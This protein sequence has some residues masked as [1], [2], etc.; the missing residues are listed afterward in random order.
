MLRFEQEDEAKGADPRFG[1]LRVRGGCTVIASADGQIRYVIGKPLPRKAGDAAE[2][3]A[4][5][6]EAMA[7]FVEQCDLADP[8]SAYEDPLANGNRMQA[9]FNLRSLH[10]E[11]L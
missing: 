7:A 2:A 4:A 9:R 1:G 5:R 11:C 10:E 3:G 6:L 8:Q